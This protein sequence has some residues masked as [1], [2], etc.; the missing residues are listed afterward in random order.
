[1][2]RDTLRPNSLE[3]A[4]FDQ[5]RRV[6]AD[7]A[8]GETIQHDGRT[9]ALTANTTCTIKSV[10]VVAEVVGGD[11]P[12][13]HGYQRAMAIVSVCNNGYR[14]GP[15]GGAHVLEALVNGARV[16][17]RPCSTNSY[18][19]LPHLEVPPAFAVPSPD[20]NPA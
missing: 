14:A 16:S 15:T 20:D 10:H 12:H 3:H 18:F 19:V 6:V 17:G 9:Y 5:I 7:R 11:R 8:N 4:V 13:T 1:M 2:S